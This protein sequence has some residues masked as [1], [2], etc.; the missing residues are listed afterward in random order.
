MGS[1]QAT[2]I[3]ECAMSH[4]AVDWDDGYCAMVRAILKGA[5][6]EPGAAQ[7]E[8][9]VCMAGLFQAMLAWMLTFGTTHN[10]GCLALAGLQTCQVTSHMLGTPIHNG[11]LQMTHV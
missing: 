1:G 5:V 3:V 2:I 11:V 8:I 10:K 4:C 9:A 6:G 7:P